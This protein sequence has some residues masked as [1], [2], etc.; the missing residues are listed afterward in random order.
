MEKVRSQEEIVNKTAI[1]LFTVLTSIIAVAYLIQL[2]KGEAGF[3]TL[4]LPIEVLD[5]VP[6]ILCWVIF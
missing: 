5:L 3:F 4:F 1:V 2:I 6:M